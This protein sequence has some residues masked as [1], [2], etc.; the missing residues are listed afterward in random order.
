LNRQV[1]RETQTFA[2][3]ASVR[4]L[5]TFISRRLVFVH[6]FKV[7]NLGPA[8]N[9]KNFRMVVSIWRDEQ[10]STMQDTAKLAPPMP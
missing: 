6:I 1:K 8:D 5:P 2:A 7:V 4:G 10:P 9:I 3:S